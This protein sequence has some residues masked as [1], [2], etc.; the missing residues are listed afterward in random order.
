[1]LLGFTRFS[2]LPVPFVRGTSF[3]ECE[4]HLLEL[5]ESQSQYGVTL[6]PVM[7]RVAMVIRL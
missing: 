6:Y 7:V 4:Q 3:D 5:A 2:L 1:M